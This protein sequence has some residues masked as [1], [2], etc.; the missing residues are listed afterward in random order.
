MGSAIQRPVLLSTATE[1]PG[2]E[3]SL[4]ILAVILLAGVG[5]GLL[6]LASLLAYRQRQTTEYL[7][8]TIA[9]GILFLRSV[10]GVG[11]VMGRVP[12]VIHHLMEHSFDFLIAAL[13]LYAVYRSKP[14][15]V[16]EESETTG[17]G[18]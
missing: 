2:V 6:F 11:T 5:T 8:I 7:L 3:G 4:L 18:Q 15:A 14:S 12:M 13:I 9:V 16:A 10:G 17:G 1:W